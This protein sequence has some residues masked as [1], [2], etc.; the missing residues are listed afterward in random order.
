MIY[1]VE[2]TGF[3]YG[4]VSE[5]FVP[6]LSLWSLTGRLF[7][8]NIQDYF[9]KCSLEEYSLPLLYSI[10]SGILLTGVNLRQWMALKI[11]SG[12]MDS[13]RWQWMSIWTCERLL[14]RFCWK[15]S[16][17]G[18][19]TYKEFSATQMEVYKCCVK[20][21]NCKPLY[22]LVSLTK[23][24]QV[25]LLMKH[26]LYASRG[27]LQDLNVYIRSDRIGLYILYTEYN[28]RL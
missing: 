11:P 23:A 26:P 27:V 16:L 8:V 9:T 5:N 28:S 25:L 7:M 18:Y 6:Q 21:F 2:E 12:E 17:T 15:E 1:I 20:Q 3:I 19:H 4:Y 13:N 10:T 14:I 24:G 22:P